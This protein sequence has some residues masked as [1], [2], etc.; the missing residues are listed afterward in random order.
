MENQPTPQRRLRDVINVVTDE[1]SINYRWYP[2]SGQ[3]NSNVQLVSVEQLSDLLRSAGTDTNVP[4]SRVTKGDILL[5]NPYNNSYVLASEAESNFIQSKIIA[6][7]VLSAKL[8][9]KRVKGTC[10]LASWEKRD[11]D[12]NGQLKYGIVEGDARVALN[13]N[14]R[15]A[16]KYTLEADYDGH[17]SSESGYEDAKAYLLASGLAGDPD[18]CAIVEGRNP[19]KG[20]QMRRRQ[21]HIE[22][23]SEMN[24]LLDAAI[25]VVPALPVLLLNT[26]IHSALSTKKTVVMTLDIEFS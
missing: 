15:V 25:T 12:A 21:Y 10:E 17:A 1:E 13:E 5:R 20:N 23:S 8:G 14:K 3:L 19:A 2:N 7:E 24:R 18:A 4:T 6:I 9:A 11:I 16:S 22:M 26:S